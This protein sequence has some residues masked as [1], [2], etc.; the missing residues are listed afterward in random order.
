M[1]DK[2][3]VV[4]N[5][6]AIIMDGNGRYAEKNNIPR[7]LGHKAGCD[8]LETILEECVKLGVKF[9]TVYAFSTENWSRSETEI[10]ALM[11]LFKLYLPRIKEKAK[12]NNVRVKFIGK[13]DRFEKDVYDSCIDL[14]NDTKNMTGTTFVIALNYGGR[15]EIVRAVNK[16]CDDVKNNKDLIIDENLFA[17]YLDTKGIDN[18]DL[19]IRTSGEMRISNFLLWQSAYSEYYFTDLFWPEF[20]ITALHKA[21]T[22]YNK[23]ERR[24]G[25]RKK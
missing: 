8:N 22:D 13:I 10:N 24:F 19:V 15:D 11:E 6:I 18:P 16:I 20:N 4:P 23:R 21:I 5:S 12:N 7:A 9:L 25:G 1:L 3:I 2:D 17:E 14:M